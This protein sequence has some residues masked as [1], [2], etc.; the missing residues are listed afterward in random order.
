MAG[1]VSFEME[2]KKEGFG[3]KIGFILAAAG[4]A[5]GLGN[6]WRFP[7]LAAKY[8][9]GIFLITY[10]IL[11]VTF[12]FSLMVTEISLGRKTGKSV[13]GAY[14]TADNRFGFLGPVA[15]AVP[16]II[17]PYYC[18]IGGW[19][20]KYFVTF[21][22]GSGKAATDD[23]FFGGFISG[24]GQPSVYFIIYAAL[25]AGVVILG[26]EKGIEKASKILMPVLVILSI[27][28]A[29]YTLTLPG[30]GA[31]LKYYVLPNF[32]GFS[33][34]MFLKTVVAAMGQLFYSMSLAMGIMV[35]YGSYMRKQDS[36]EGS[37]RQISFFDTLIAILAGLIIVP[38]VFIFSGGDADALNAGPG[39]MFVTLPKVFDSMKGGHIVG[40]AFFVLVTFA[41][42]TSSV[43]LLETMVSIVTEKFKLKRVGS[44]VVCLLIVFVMGML[45]VLGYSSWS[46]VTIF[47]YQILDFFDFIS[48]NIMMPIVALLT[49]IL[50][51]Y[52]V[53]PKYIEDETTL[54]GEKFKSKGLYEV[55]TK[56]VCPAFMIIILLTPF[57]TEI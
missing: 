55:M 53:K 30:A 57:L 46:E 11:V 51:G 28:I 50:I 42:L 34:K 43:S 6:I 7:Y 2:E 32:E 18:V 23:G 37:T 3:S 29:I 16:F 4:S 10:I 36:I 54:N 41:A 21:I 45:S 22:S 15:A 1:K 17:T 49:C 19:V 24:F 39:L 33:F 13:I 31:G 38:S 35:T 47:G 8:G 44:T 14:K 5:I 40:G 9:G 20:L 52:I 26:V 56:Y 27:G 48:N 25:T 12:G